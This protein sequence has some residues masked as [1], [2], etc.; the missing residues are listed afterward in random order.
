MKK[1]IS[2]GLVLTM[3]LILVAVTA[4]AVTLLSGREFVEEVV[5]PMAQ[6]NDTDEQQEDFSGSE[7]EAVI[8]AAE[9]N[10]ISLEKQFELAIESGKGYAEEEVVMTIARET[11][12][13]NYSEWTIE[14]KHWFGEMMVKIGFR[15]ENSACLPD[16]DELS[17]EQAMT[18]V[19]KK[20]LA[21][22]G[23]DI[24]DA[25]TWKCIVEYEAG[26]DEWG[27]TTPPI[28]N[29]DLIPVEMGGNQYSLTMDSDGNIQSFKVVAALNGNSG[30]AVV[31]QYQ[32]IYGGFADWNYETWASLG[33]A[34][35]ER[36]PDTRTC[37][38]LQNVEYILPPPNGITEDRAKEIALDAVNLEYTSINGSIC[39]MDGETPIWKILTRTKRPEDSGSG[40]YSTIWFVEIDCM[41]GEV[42]EKKEYVVGSEMDP[43]CQWVPW[44]VLQNLPPMPA[45]PNG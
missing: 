8:K 42:R 43:L 13:G 21:D 25:S 40:K 44:N 39:C 1:K 9:E 41:T 26:K 30:R 24:L 29:F 32:S 28:W 2:V 17:F 5:V 6:E 23:D 37:W 4:L 31:D 15:E 12:G 34:L 10:N 7:L 35:K 16:E 45:G 22:Y 11:F 38:A 27:N 19:Q 3:V 18:I 14:Q 33:N 36:W 20:I